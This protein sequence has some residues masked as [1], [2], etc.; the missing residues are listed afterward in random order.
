MA[1]VDGYNP[2]MYIKKNKNKII[3]LMKG[4]MKM[5]KLV[6]LILSLGLVS[7]PVYADEYE[8]DYD[9][10]TYPVE[11]TYTEEVATPVSTPGAFVS[12]QF[13]KAGLQYKAVPKTN[14]FSPD[15]FT[16]E[17]KDSIVIKNEWDERK[18]LTPD[19]KNETR[20]YLPEVFASLRIPTGYSVSKVS[21]DPQ[22]PNSTLYKFKGTNHQID[23]L[24]VQ[25]NKIN[26][27]GN[28]DFQYDQSLFY[29][30]TASATNDSMLLEINPIFV[31]EETARVQALEIFDVYG[32]TAEDVF[33][34]FYVVSVTGP[35]RKN[36]VDRMITGLELVEINQ[37][38]NYLAQGA[39][40]YNKNQIQVKY[41]KDAPVPVP[42]VKKQTKPVQQPKINNTNPGMGGDEFADRFMDIYTKSLIYGD[43]YN[44]DVDM[45]NLVKDMYRPH[46]TPEEQ[47]WM[48]LIY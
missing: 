28:V 17:R 33:G 7:I 26:L 27:V 35:N 48:D 20:V 43:S 44:P 47:M 15:R 9:Q 19:T 42:V 14:S 38:I 4:K 1:K 32:F 2:P 10:Y 12:D 18:V 11:E 8:Y 39:N 34:N 24:V 5:K 13:A 41:E 6:A 40:Y 23:A 29:K 36:I 45:T 22:V 25:K 3:Q 16:I 30:L 46:L 31:V 37:S 21:L